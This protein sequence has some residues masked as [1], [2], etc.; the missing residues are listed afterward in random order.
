LLNEN[1]HINNISLPL[2]VYILP[3]IIIGI[4][5]FIFILVLRQYFIHFKNMS[6]IQQANFAKQTLIVTSTIMIIVLS[7]STLLFIFEIISHIVDF[8]IYFYF[9]HETIWR[10]S[11]EFLPMSTLIILI[12]FAHSFSYFIKLTDQNKINDKTL[13]HILLIIFAVFWNVVL[14]SSSFIV[15]SFPFIVGRLSGNYYDETGDSIFRLVFST[16]SIILIFSIFYLVGKRK[17]VHLEYERFSYPLKIYSIISLIILS[18]IRIGWFIWGVLFTESM[19]DD[20][21]GN[22]N[23]ILFYGYLIIRLL[24]SINYLVFFSEILLKFRKVNI[25]QYIDLGD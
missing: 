14:F 19:P 15:D 9:Y 5:I 23:T 10:I 7:L 20:Y 22:V 11:G 24:I 13:I 6:R 17:L 25:E 12:F 18:A 2:W 8:N 1:F 16:L 3:F 21:D 4:Y